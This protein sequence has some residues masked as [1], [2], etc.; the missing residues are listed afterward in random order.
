MSRVQS[1][2]PV[3]EALNA[4]VR[5]RHGLVGEVVAPRVGPAVGQGDDVGEEPLV[6]GAAAGGAQRRVA[7]EQVPALRVGVA[8]AHRV[9]RP[10]HLEAGGLRGVGVG[11]DLLSGRSV[12]QRSVDHDLEP[13]LADPL[14]PARA[15]IGRARRCAG[16][17]D[18][19]GR[20]LRRRG[21]SVDG[22]RDGP[23]EQ[24]Q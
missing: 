2:D 14:Q 18:A 21:G 12:Q 9:Q 11:D 20:Q 10:D 3:D 23:Q 5:R 24:A 4:C 17:V 16:L 8:E 7:V 1:L 13:G 19:L 22:R 6:V 15:A